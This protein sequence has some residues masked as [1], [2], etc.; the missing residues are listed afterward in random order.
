MVIKASRI[1]KKLDVKAHRFEDSKIDKV[2]YE[3][4]YNFR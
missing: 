4:G 1:I 3:F 2:D